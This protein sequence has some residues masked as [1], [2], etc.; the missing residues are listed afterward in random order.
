MR[1]FKK[2]LDNS[3]KMRRSSLKKYIFKEA[4]MTDYPHFVKD[5]LIEIVNQM[6]ADPKLFVKN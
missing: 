5:K 3:K 1:N 6:A 4:I 2:V